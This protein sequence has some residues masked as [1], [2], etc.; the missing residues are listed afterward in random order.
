MAAN[1]GEKNVWQI[2][3]GTWRILKDSRPHVDDI[4]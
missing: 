3:N 4:T 1:L 2:A